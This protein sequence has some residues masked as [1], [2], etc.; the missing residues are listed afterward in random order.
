VKPGST[1]VVAFIPIGQV[2]RITEFRWASPVAASRYLLVV[3]NG[4]TSEVLRR[5]TAEQQF[6][7]GPELSERFQPGQY[8]WTV[9][10]LDRDGRV[11]AQSIVETF[12]LR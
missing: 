10:A 12:E 1:E 2:R 7:I 9:E 3:R 8:K 6:D 11:V 5:E 4:G